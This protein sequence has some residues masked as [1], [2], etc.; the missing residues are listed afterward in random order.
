MDSNRD[1]MADVMGCPSKIGL[2]KDL[3]LLAL[4]WALS[5]VRA[6]PLR[7]CS[8]CSVSYCMERPL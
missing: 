8:C 1:S 3:C 2:Q 5:G 4:S 6:F 7:E